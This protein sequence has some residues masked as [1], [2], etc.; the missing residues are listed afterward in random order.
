MAPLGEWYAADIKVKQRMFQ[1]DY[2]FQQ[3]SSC[4]QRTS[5][6]HV[7]FDYV[8]QVFALLVQYLNESR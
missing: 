6:F 2:C 7:I 1:Q 4:Q 3:F 5:R 8:P